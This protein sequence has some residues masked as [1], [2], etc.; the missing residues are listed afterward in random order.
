MFGF[1][2]LCTLTQR[3]PA[4]LTKI[5]VSILDSGPSRYAL[6]SSFNT[7]DSL[8]YKQELGDSLL[9]IAK[10]V[11]DGVLVF[12]ASYTAMTSAIES[13]QAGPQPNMWCVTAGTC[14]AMKQPLQ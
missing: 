7:R 10:I 1:V 2:V 4:C 5:W 9:H 13:W 14:D 3:S 12:F 8:E 11:P 6:N